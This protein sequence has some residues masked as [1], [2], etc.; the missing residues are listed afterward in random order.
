MG[1][2]ISAGWNW[3]TTGSTVAASAAPA[4]ASAAP[5]TV[6]GLSQIGSVLS[7]ASTGFGIYNSFSG[8][9]GSSAPKAPNPT[10][11]EAAAK[12]QAVKDI[13]ARRRKVASIGRQSTF[14]TSD[15]GGLK[16]KPKTRTKK[17][18]GQGG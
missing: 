8:S 3:L 2:Y 7:I 10:L 15:Q 1:G 14:K 18:L 13:N 4:A 6:S 17:L 11:A 9:G 12:N 5:A 16:A